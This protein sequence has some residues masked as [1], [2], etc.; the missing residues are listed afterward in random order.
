MKRLLLPLLAALALPTAVN[1]EEF[2]ELKPINPHSYKKSTLIKWEENGKRYLTFKGTSVVLDCYGDRGQ[3]GACPSPFGNNPDA[4]YEKRKATEVINKY[5]WK[6][7]LFE[8]S[9]DCDEKTYNREG[10]VM[11]WT[12]LLIDQ[13]PFLVAQKYC[14]IEEWS[15]LPNK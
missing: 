7:V 15:K 13:T 4:I 3:F 10:D 6:T 5:G 11:T 2:T 9:I 1:A 12:G 14:P 8:Y